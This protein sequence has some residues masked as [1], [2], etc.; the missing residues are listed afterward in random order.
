MQ[1]RRVFHDDDFHSWSWS[2]HWHSRGLGPG[3]RRRNYVD[4]AATHGWCVH[5]PDRRER[6]RQV[7]DILTLTWTV[8]RGEYTGSDGRLALFRAIQSHDGWY[9]YDQ[10]ND[11]KIIGGPFKKLED[12]QEYAAQE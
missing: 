3:E 9:L 5:L 12:A 11:G 10:L 2:R 6:H 4:R 8:H 1:V 7:G